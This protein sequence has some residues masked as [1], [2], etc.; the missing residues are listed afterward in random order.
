MLR[1]AL[2]AI[3]LL[4]P[5]GALADALPDCPPGTHMVMNP[6]PPGAMHH[7][8][9]GCVPDAPPTDPAPPAEPAPPAAAP[10]PPPPPA[11]APAPAAT[12]AASSGCRASPASSAAFGALVPFALAVLVLRRLRAA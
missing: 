11:P 7:G 5:S 8:G 1:A 4:A 3:A 6:T 2:L 12:P 9:G 10:P